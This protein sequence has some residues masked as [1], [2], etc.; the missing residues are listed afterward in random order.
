MC[1]VPR[2]GRFGRRPDGGRRGA[3]ADA[4]VEWTKPDDILFDA[5]SEMLKLLRFDKLGKSMIGMADGSVRK[6]KK[7]IGEET[8][9]AIITRAGGEVYTLDDD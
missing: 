9:K 8:L 3:V 4:A 5:N 6:L 7:T 2:V 1:H